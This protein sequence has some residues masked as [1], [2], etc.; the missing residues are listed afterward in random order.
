MIGLS[1]LDECKSVDSRFSDISKTS[2]INRKE[3]LQDYLKFRDYLKILFGVVIDEVWKFWH[4]KQD[5]IK[6]DTNP[7]LGRNLLE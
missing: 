6:L 2:M 7:K 5:K 3:V 4:V 1:F